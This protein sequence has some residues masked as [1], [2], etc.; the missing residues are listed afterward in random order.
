MINRE[1]QLGNEVYLNSGSPALR[2]IA[3]D[4]QKEHVAVEWVRDG[5]VDRA[6]FPTVCVRERNG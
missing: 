1:L 6:I 2:V 3:L 4:L 5:L